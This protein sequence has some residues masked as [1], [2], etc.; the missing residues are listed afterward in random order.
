MA[1]SLRIVCAAAVA[2]MVAAGHAHADTM[3]QLDFHNPLTLAQVVW[4]A[5][6]FGTFYLLAA[7]WGLP[8]VA[9]VLET[10]ART[11]AGDLEQARTSKMAADAAVA[12]LDAARSR[13][14]AQSQAAIALATQAAKTAAV[15]AAIAQDARLDAQLAASEAQIGQARETAL[16]AL[17]QVATETASAVVLRL[18]GGQIAELRVQSAVGELLRERGLS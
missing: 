5:V 7:N 18:T 4:G 11:I 2:S 17:R 16:G 14:Y 13:A 10:R 12:E 3:P 9:A 8:K 1:R 15:A 6:I